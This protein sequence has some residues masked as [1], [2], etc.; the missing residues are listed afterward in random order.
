MA[1]TKYTF[2]KSPVSPNGLTDEIRAS[3]IVTALDHISTVG[4]TVDIWF[5]DALSE[6]DQ[7]TLATLV[8]NH[9]GTF[10]PLETP[11]DDE[12]APVQRVKAA[13]A[14]WTL[15]FH[16]IEFTS[17]KVGGVYNKTV[18][19]NTGVE[20]DLGFATIKLF[21][22]GGA[23][24]TDAANEGDCVHTRIDWCTSFDIAVRAASLSQATRPLSDLRCWVTVAPN[25]A[26]KR[27]CQGG[28]NF[29]HFDP[30]QFVNVEGMASKFLSASSP[31]AGINKFRIILKHPA[32]FQHTAQLLLV[33]Y[34]A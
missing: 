4:S 13:A 30:G 20:S 12:G 28:M 24:I 14:G 15:Q 22:A 25:I 33:T 32:G 8:T 10:R 9:S 21:D 17:A 31:M 2:T 29:K 18:D 7:T 3:S 26:N 19:V 23:E 27:L 6:G 16:S 11:T 5:K 34:V 1:L